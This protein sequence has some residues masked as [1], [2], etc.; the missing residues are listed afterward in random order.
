MRKILYLLIT[1][2]LYT[3]SSFAQSF[4]SIMKS[5]QKQAFIEMRGKIDKRLSKEPNN[6]ESLFA[7]SKY[8]EAEANTTFY[9]L[10]SAYRYAQ[11]VHRELGTTDNATKSKMKKLGITPKV[12]A[13]YKENIALRVFEKVEQQ[14]TEQAYSQFY[15]F[16]KNEPAALVA[17]QRRDN[18]AYQRAISIGTVGSYQ[19][20]LQKYPNAE[21]AEEV[22]SKYNALLYK[23]ITSDRTPESFHQFITE[24]PQSPYREAAELLLFKSSIKHHNKQQYER[25]IAQFPNSPF[26]ALAKANVWFLSEEKKDLLQSVP[27]KVGKFAFEKEWNLKQ[28]SYLPFVENGKFGFINPEGIIQCKAIYDSIPEDYK[29]VGLEEA[30]FIAYQNEK[31]GAFNKSGEQFINFSYDA[32]SPFSEGVFMVKNGNK[33]GLM[34]Q[35]GF[36]ML[37][38][39]YQIL[40]PIK[41][42]WVKF[43]KGKKYGVIS[44]YGDTLVAPIYDAIKEGPA[45][46]IIAS[47]NDQNRLIHLDREVSEAAS[48][49]VFSS[50]EVTQSNYLILKDTDGYRVLNSEGD[51]LLNS[52]YSQV[53][54]TNWGWVAKEQNSFLIYNKEGNLISPIRYDN[55]LVG[56][57]EYGIKT[58]GKWGVLDYQGDLMIQP[59]YDTLY[60]LSDVGI[61]L[62][63][64]ERKVGYFY[65]DEMMDYSQ[66]SQI[67]IQAVEEQESQETTIFIV[68][69]NGRGK[70]GLIS[71]SGERILPNKY[72]DIKVMPQGVILVEQRKKK[73]LTNW[74]GKLLTPILYDGIANYNQRFFSLLRS[75]KFGFL[76]L[77]DNKIITTEYDALVKKYGNSDSL[78]IA[79][80]GQFG[81][82]DINNEQITDF[83]FQEIHYWNDSTLLGKH[84][85]KWS[86]YNFKQRRFLPEET[87]DTFSFVR[88]DGKETVIKTFKSTGYGLLSNKIGR[89]V[90][91]EYTGIINLGTYTKPVYFLEKTVA[92]SNLYISLYLNGK[93]NVIREQVLDAENYEK[94]ICQE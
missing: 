55:V 56:R 6:I 36:E 78:L 40:E 70:K 79:K 66:Y 93:G 19:D 92:K 10:D 61:L 90:A 89:I 62:E 14:N 84:N 71:F 28:E 88:N 80:K 3:S 53:K 64:D 1:L 65:K 37:P 54:E 50:Y 76:S 33:Q 39:Q 81:L 30:Y 12:V 87:F 49:F 4:K 60:F 73:G 29:C 8:Y 20:F 75:K 51:L 2:L 48:E 43:N 46:L 63:R 68:T 41:G 58:I 74:E 91:D 21:Q 26:V 16:Y 77:N 18:I 5:F 35:T 17:Q 24:N 31:V 52:S 94:I 9:S 34:H 45:N 22:K 7:Y 72:D 82:I 42:Q 86:L 23:S 67:D 15:S 32:I 38:C 69:K 83:S 57:N 44:Y 13:V 27:S 85:G 59:L 11:V 47:L 25:F